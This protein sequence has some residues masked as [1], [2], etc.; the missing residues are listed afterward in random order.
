MCVILHLSIKSNPKISSGLGG[1]YFRVTNFITVDY[2]WSEF[3]TIF[4]YTRFETFSN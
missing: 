2:C 4:G 3:I 1:V